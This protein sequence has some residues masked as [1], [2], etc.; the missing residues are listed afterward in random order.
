MADSNSHPSTDA[1]PAMDA[2]DLMILNKS[3]VA[4]AAGA[5]PS[6][7]QLYNLIVK[8][9]DRRDPLIQLYAELGEFGQ[10]LEALRMSFDGSLSR[11]TKNEQEMLQECRQLLQDCK[12][13][14]DELFAKLSA[15]ARDDIQ[16]GLIAVSDA[17]VKLHIWKMR[18]D[19]MAIVMQ[20]NPDGTDLA[21][22][23]EVG[24]AIESVQWDI[25]T[26][27]R[28]VNCQLRSFSQG[29]DHDEETDPAAWDILQKIL[30]PWKIRQAALLKS[31]KVCETV[32]EV[33][34]EKQTPEIAEYIAVDNR[35]DFISLA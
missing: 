10:V 5:A 28:Q 15:W 18:L 7:T 2:I 24:K 26:E 22:A 9:Q 35:C 1:L 14:C 20:F 11:V 25:S 3:V 29:M 27:L 32:A 17:A 34:K 30:L 4:A 19:P 31:I 21:K 8:L 13:V 6:I 23:D 12:I 16:H 33:L